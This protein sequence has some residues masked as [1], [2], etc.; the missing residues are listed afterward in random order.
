MYYKRGIP[1]I[2]VI[3]VHVT[4][5]IHDIIHA[6]IIIILH[7]YIVSLTKSTIVYFERIIYF[8]N[9]FQ[10]AIAPNSGNFTAIQY[11]CGK[12][13]LYKITPNQITPVTPVYH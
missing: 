10:W 12:F 6:I 8:S 5:N 7:V 11:E 4:F 9:T 13:I 3:H 1:Y 2:H